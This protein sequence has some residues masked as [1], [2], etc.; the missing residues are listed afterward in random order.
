MLEVAKVLVR[1]VVVPFLV[2]VAVNLFV[3]WLL[4]R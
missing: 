4:A 3:A 1:Y 2:G